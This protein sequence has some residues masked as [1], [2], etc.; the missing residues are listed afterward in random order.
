MIPFK[1]ML[2]VR[3]IMTQRPCTELAELV[4]VATGFIAQKEKAPTYVIE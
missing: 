3:Q 2:H 1:T 4:S